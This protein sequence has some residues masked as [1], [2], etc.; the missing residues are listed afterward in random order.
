L[1]FSRALRLHPDKGGD[2]KI[3]KEVTHA[4]VRCWISVS[5]FGIS[6][7]NYLEVAV[8]AAEV[9]ANRRISMYFSAEI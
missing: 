9:I 2:T 8:V 6:S 7:A 1:F 3:F 5:A 4:L